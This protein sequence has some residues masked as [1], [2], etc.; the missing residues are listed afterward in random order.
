MEELKLNP[1]KSMQLFVDNK[2]AINLSK[3]QVFHFLKDQVS[4]EELELVYCNAED[5][6]LLIS[7]PKYYTFES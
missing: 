1:K 6:K 3:N 7:S 2:Y 5:P 4:E